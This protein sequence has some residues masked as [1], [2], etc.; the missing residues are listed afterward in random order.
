[1]LA[2]CHALHLLQVADRESH[3]VAEA[4]ETAARLQRERRAVGR[5]FETSRDM[6]EVLRLTMD[7]WRSNKDDMDAYL[8]GLKQ[9][10]RAIGGLQQDCE[11]YVDVGHVE[12]T[13]E[14]TLQMMQACQHRFEEAQKKWWDA[15]QEY[16]SEQP[17]LRMSSPEDYGVDSE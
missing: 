5:V 10:Y 17:D 1:M 4:R 8:H 3:A 7:L 15:K 11:D 9:K 13:V 16:Q 12:D 14:E 6:Y 2:A